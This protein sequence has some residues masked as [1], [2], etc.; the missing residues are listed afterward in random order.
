MTAVRRLLIAYMAVAALPLGAQTRPTTTQTTTT[1]PRTT[2]ATQPTPRVTAP[3]T[4]E[5]DEDLN[6]PRALRLSLKE[7]IDT[8]I[9]NNL[10][11][12]VQRLDFSMA[13][14]NY[15]GSYGIY[16]F[17]SNARLLQASTENPTISQFQSSG[18]KSTIFDIG[19]SQLLPSGATY[20]AAFNNSRATTVGGGTTVSPAYRSDLSLDFTQPLLRD[21]GSDITGR[22]ITIARNNLGISDQQFRLALMQQ[23]DAATQAYL[24]LVYARQNV[25]VV[26]QTLFLARDQARITQIRIDVG[27][28]AP[29]DILQPNVQIATT[30][31]TLITAVAV[32]RGAED[33]LRQLMHLPPAEWERPIIPTDNVSYGPVSLDMAHAVD[34]AYKL[35]PELHEQSLVTDTRKLQYIYARNQVLPRVDFT[36]NYNPAGLAGRSIVLD[37]VTGQPTGRINT[38]GLGSAINQVFGGDFT[39]WTVGFNFAMPIRNIGAKAEAKRA[40]LDWKASQVTEAELRENVAVEVRGNVRTVDTLAKQIAA[41]RAARE[42]A[43]QNVEAERKRY[44]N[45]MVTNFEVLQI[46]EQLADARVRELQALVAYN[47]ALSTYHLSTGDL[48][49]VHNI[50]V[51]EPPVDDPQIFSSFDRY[52][53]LRYENRLDMKGKPSDQ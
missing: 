38:S 36:A 23:A 31:E 20:T 24:N 37:P 32:V 18:G 19:V 28:S 41:T 7:A 5:T 8:T 2:A 45:G 34:L 33:A 15:R 13:G 43:E 35:R 12:H 46:Q 9:Q 50:R 42:A 10:G 1:T 11:V 26:K 30:E 21:F 47:K 16:D 29:L 40:E 52:N 6:S 39:S 3:V 53:W 4:A 25:D 17:F 44:E 51:D 14:Q 49:E 22:G 27:A 48:L